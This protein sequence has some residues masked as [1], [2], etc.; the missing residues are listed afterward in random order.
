MDAVDSK[1]WSSFTEKEKEEIEAKEVNL[2]FGI[3]GQF[4]AGTPLVL[5]DI[6]VVVVDIV[7]D[8]VVVCC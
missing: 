5:V 8:I 7:V 2:L 6:I 4:G 3:L 1:K